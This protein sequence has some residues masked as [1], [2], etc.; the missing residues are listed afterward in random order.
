M[1]ASGA[2]LKM[3]GTIKPADEARE[4]KEVA[5]AGT[6]GGTRCWSDA[7]GVELLAGTLGGSA[8]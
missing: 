1:I 8:A 2:N 4:R 6:L 7:E 5:Q 3:H